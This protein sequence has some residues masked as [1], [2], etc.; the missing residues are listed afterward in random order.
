[1]SSKWDEYSPDDDTIN[2]DG[3]DDE[4]DYEFE[5]IVHL[6]IDGTLDLH[7]FS[8]REVKE[9]VPDY[10]EEC[11]DAEI[12]EVRIVHG[13][14]K[15]VLRRIVHA[16]LDRLDYVDSYRTAG[17]GRGSWGATL[18]TLKQTETAPPNS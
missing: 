7:T 1:M 6:P 2:S 11:R 16:V 12:F 3:D 4:N 9:L 17:H 13:K 15:G 8:P 10:L 5:E 14:G 18:V